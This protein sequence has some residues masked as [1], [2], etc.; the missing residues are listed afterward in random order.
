MCRR[1]VMLMLP[2]VGRELRVDNPAERH[3]PERESSDDTLSNLMSHRLLSKSRCLDRLVFLNPCN[4]FI[5]LLFGEQATF[6][7]FLYAAIL[8]DEDAH[9]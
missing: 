1:A 7:V 4:D 5:D 2:D 3:K 9:G 6:D 8:I